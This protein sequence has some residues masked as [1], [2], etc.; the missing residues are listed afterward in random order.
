MERS[1]YSIKP[2]AG[3]GLIGF[4]ANFNI[5][6]EFEPAWWKIKGNGLEFL[7]RVEGCRL[8]HT[9]KLSILWS[10]ILKP[11]IFISRPIPDNVVARLSQVCQVDMWHTSETLPPIA[12]KISDLDGLMT[13]GHEPVTAEMMDTAPNL[14]VITTVGVGYDHVDAVAAKR[15]NISVGNTPDVLSATTADMTF[16]L[17]LSVARNVV[18]GN[19]FV[20][21][22]QWSYYDPNILWGQEVHDATIGIVGMGRIG[23]AVAKRALG[24]DMRVLYNKRQ[25]RLDWEEELGIEY[26]ELNDLLQSSDFVTLHPP[27][28]DETYHL[29]GQRELALMKP[30]AILVNIARGP[31]VD[32]RALYQALKDREIAG[33]ALDVTEPEP[34]NPDHP[35]LTL[36][37]VVI[38]P[39]LGSATNQTRMKMANMAT[40]NI[41]AGLKGQPLP[42]EVAATR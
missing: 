23:Y 9:K 38:C 12:E 3:K 37:N 14:K 41:L 42:Y 21:N 10:C 34:I 35:L 31:V 7:A 16:A 19:T 2:N 15:R 29:I 28:S 40:D 22:K 33:A 1:R 17:L 4:I 27:M 25:R 5:A 30:N 18:P 11:K 32:G 20:Q 6:G 24:F 39:H 8:H 36:D 13:Y 26:A